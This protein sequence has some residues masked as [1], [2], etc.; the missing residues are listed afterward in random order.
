MKILRGGRSRLV[1]LSLRLSS[2]PK[3]LIC[4]FIRKSAH[5]RQ[6]EMQAL[7]MP[8]ARVI[9][10]AK[11]QRAPEFRMDEQCEDVPSCGSIGLQEPRQSALYETTWTHTRYRPVACIAVLRHTH[12]TNGYK[13]IILRRR[14][15]SPARHRRVACKGEDDLEISGLRI[16]CPRLSWPC[17]RPFKRSRS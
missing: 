8:G 11:Q 7:L 4:E 16:R 13:T 2:R 17:C 9:C 10:R 5:R 6:D 1:A 14:K 15:W 3:T 12:L